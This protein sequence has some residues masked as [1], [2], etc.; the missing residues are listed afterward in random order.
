MRTFGIYIIVIGLLSIV[1]HFLNMNFIFL[2]WIDQ[3]GPEKGW[4]IRGGITLLGGLLW[5]IGRRRQ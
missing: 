1:L 4:I 3:W 2:N 5:L